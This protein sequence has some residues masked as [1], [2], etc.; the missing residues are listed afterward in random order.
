ML[1]LNCR[2]GDMEITNLLILG[3]FFKLITF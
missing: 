3:F 1:V 2:R